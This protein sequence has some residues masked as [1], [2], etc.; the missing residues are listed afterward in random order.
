MVLMLQRLIKLIEHPPSRVM[1]KVLGQ[2]QTYS[3]I[4]Q[5]QRDVI[6]L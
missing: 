3:Q 5:A 6:K 4:M 1:Y 2:G